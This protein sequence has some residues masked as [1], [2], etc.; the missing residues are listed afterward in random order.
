MLLL[1]V[2][3]FLARGVCVLS[4]HLFWTYGLWTAGVAQ[5]EGHTGFFHLPSAVLAFIFVARRIQPFLSLVDRD[6]E[7]CVLTI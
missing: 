5:E 2:N 7:F 6:I 1:I 3:I 4:S